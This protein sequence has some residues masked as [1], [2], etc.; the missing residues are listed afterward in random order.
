MIR[1]PVTGVRGL[2]SCDCVPGHFLLLEIRE[3]KNQHALAPFS[4]WR[5][6]P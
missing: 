6:R 1:S 4:A 5:K 3:T 2:S